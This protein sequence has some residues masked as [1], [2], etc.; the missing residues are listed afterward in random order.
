MS[1]ISATGLSKAYRH[2][3]H[4]RDRFL[5]LLPGFRKKRHSLEWAV[6]DVTFTVEDGEAVG[7]IGLNGAG[8]STL[9]RLLT[10]TTAPTAGKFTVEGQVAALLE[11]VQASNVM[12]TEVGGSAER[13]NSHFISQHFFCHLATFL[14][15]LPALFV[16]F[17]QCELYDKY[18]R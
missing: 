9:L 15:K 10:G 7:I 5:E 2:Y 11:R 17:L 3:A 12:I 6:R 16:L 1:R 4:P 14:F 13:K 8:K 18:A